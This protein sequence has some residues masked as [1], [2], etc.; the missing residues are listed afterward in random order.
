MTGSTI[1][2]V[3]CSSV[4]T[5]WKSLG[6]TGVDQASAGG[7][8]RHRR[9]EQVAH[10]VRR[11][12]VRNTARRW[13]SS[14]SPAALAPASIIRSS[15]R[16]PARPGTAGRHDDRAQVVGRTGP[17]AGSEGAAR[18]STSREA[19]VRARTPTAELPRPPSPGSPMRPARA[20][21][22]PGDS[23]ATRRA[24]SPDPT[25]G[26]ADGRPDADRPPLRLAA[27]R[28]AACRSGLCARHAWR[29]SLA[30]HRPRDTSLSPRPLPSYRLLLRWDR[31]LLGRMAAGRKRRVQ[32][33]RR[34]C[35]PGA[36]GRSWQNR[37]VT[38]TQ[39]IVLGLLVVAFAS[40]WVARGGDTGRRGADAD[41]R[42]TPSPTKRRPRTRMTPR[43]LRSRTLRGR[44]QPQLDSCSRRRWTTCKR[45]STCG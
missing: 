31:A 32:R 28:A 44:P 18:S 10:G 30:I 16:R 19:S 37:G 22:A 42:A 40:G 15:I 11:Q 5:P 8:G 17:S 3:G 6:R 45:S 21:S 39:I 24:R 41:A 12:H 33:Q 36:S 7:E 20:P 1:V 9:E 13:S 43:R 25:R 34:R 23:R 2:T 29:A 4:S 27:K 26:A 38:S 35:W 14:T